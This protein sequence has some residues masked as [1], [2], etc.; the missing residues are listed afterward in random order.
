MPLPPPP[1]KR[2]LT[3][4]R[5]RPKPPFLTL[6]RRSMNEAVRGWINSP[7]HAANLFNPEFRETGIAVQ[8]NPKD[9]YLYFT[10]VFV[11]PG[12]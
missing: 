8:M 3:L 10:Q 9:G 5:L 6:A 1:F 12:R 2:G 7:T 11:N 4:A